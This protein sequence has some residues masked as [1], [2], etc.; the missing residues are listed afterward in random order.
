MMNSSRQFTIKACL[1]RIKIR[2]KKTKITKA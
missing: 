2:L 1:N